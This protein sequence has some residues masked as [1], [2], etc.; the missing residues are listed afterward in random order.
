[1]P[2]PTSHVTLAELLLLNLRPHEWSINQFY[3][4]LLLSYPQQNDHKLCNIS[5]L[6]EAED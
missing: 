3:L 6:S 1:M 5:H 2:T 4:N